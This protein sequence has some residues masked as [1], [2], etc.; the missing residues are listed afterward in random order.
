MDKF[1]SLENEIWVDAKSFTTDYSGHYIVSNLGRCYN[2]KTKRFVGHWA[3]GYWHINLSK[4]GRN[5]TMMVGRLM[6]ISFNIPIPKHLQGLTTNK[7]QSMHLDGDSHNNSL[8]NLAWGDAKENCNE[9]NWKIRQSEEQKGKWY[10]EEYRKRMSEVHKGKH[11]SEEAKR[12]IGEAMK[13]KLHSEETKIKMSEAKK[14]PI[15]Q[16]SKYGEFLKEWDSALLVEK[17]V[18]IYKSS[19]SACARGKRPTAGGFIWK[20]KKEEA[21]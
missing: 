9:V 1:E 11:H 4:N 13:G 17:E 7:L 15:I 2:C 8:S 14:K 3:N 12:K 5:E 10:S 20:Y 18:G 21:V 16:Y 6:L 19:I